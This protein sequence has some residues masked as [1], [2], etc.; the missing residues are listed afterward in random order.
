MLVSGTC[1]SKWQAVESGPSERTIW[2]G[3]RTPPGGP[4]GGEGGTAGVPRFTVQGELLPKT[5][6]PGCFFL[7]R[8][9]DPPLIL[10]LSIRI[11][12]QQE[13]RRTHQRETE[14]KVLNKVEDASTLAGDHSPWVREVLCSHCANLYWFLTDYCRKLLYASFAA[15]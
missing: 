4:W 5:V 1:S 9:L 7:S 15:M 14:Q 3:K 12:S 2:W 8:F 11:P 13:G 6:C 10:S